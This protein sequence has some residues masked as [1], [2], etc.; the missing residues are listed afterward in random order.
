LWTEWSF[1][2]PSPSQGIGFENQIAEEFQNATN[3]HRPGAFLRVAANR[4]TR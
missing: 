1:H 2:H 4:I 3:D